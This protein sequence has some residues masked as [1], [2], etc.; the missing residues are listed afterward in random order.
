MH[1]SGTS[2]LTGILHYLGVE[3]GT[4]MMPAR[5]ENP[6]GFF[7]NQRV[8]E[9]NEA[10]LTENGSAWDD[11]GPE[12]E[13]GLVPDFERYVRKAIAVVKDQFSY[14]RTFAI[15]D[16]R[17]CRLF[18]VWRRA[19]EELGIDIAVV[20]PYRNPLEIASSLKRRNGFS[21]EKSIL[22]WADHV[23][24]AERHSRSLNR[25][26]ISFDRLLANDKRTI[27][28]LCDAL[29]LK[30]TTDRRKN[31]SAFLDRKL[32]HHYSPADNISDALPV[33]LLE[34]TQLL[35]KGRMND[36][37][38]LDRLR[39][40][41][42]SNRDFF[43]GA[44]VLESMP[45]YRQLTAELETR[46]ARIVE[47]QDEV[48]EKNQWAASLNQ[49]IEQL[50][51]LADRQ[52][53]ELEQRGGLLEQRDRELE[54][55][56]QW[57]ASLNQ[58]LE[59]LR[60]LA[61]RLGT[62]LEQSNGVLQQREQELEEKNQLAA[63]LD[64][65][66]EQLRQ[67]ADRLGAELE[68]RDG[69][70][71]Q[72]DR[73]LEEK[74]QRAA[75]LDQ[76]LEQLR[77]LAD[78]LGA[79]LEQ[80]N[81][82]LQQREQELEQARGEIERLNQL[83]QGHAAQVDS[84]NEQLA[85]ARQEAAELVVR[86]QELATE[87]DGIQR[88]LR[89]QLEAAL[90]KVAQREQWLEEKRV[91]REALERTY[92]EAVQGVRGLLDETRSEIAERD[93]RIEELIREHEKWRLSK[94]DALRSVNEQ[95]VVASAAVEEKTRLLELREREHA[96]EVGQYREE[97]ATL[98]D[99]IARL[100]SGN[101]ELEQRLDEQSLERKAMLSAYETALE[102]QAGKSRAEREE[103]VQRL[104]QLQQEIE[105][106]EAMLTALDLALDEVNGRSVH[107]RELIA[108]LEQAID[109]QEEGRRTES[110]EARM[111]AER[112]EQ[113][114]DEIGAMK[115]EL[116]Q[117]QQ[118]L[119]AVEARERKLVG[120]SEKIGM[121]C[122]NV[123]AFYHLRDKHGTALL[124]RSFR[125]LLDY[126]HPFGI[127][128]RVRHSL[129]ASR[130]VREKFDLIPREFLE[131]FDAGRYLDANPDVADAVAEG[132]FENALEHFIFY[133]YDEVRGGVRRLY[134]GVPGFNE[135]EY[136]NRYEDV[137]IAVAEGA[138][139]SGYD[140][141]LRYGAEE[142]L[143]GARLDRDVDVDSD[144]LRLFHPDQVVF[145]PG[146]LLQ[147]PRFDEPVV[148]I[149]IPAYNQA[150]FTFAC[151]ESVIA[152]SGAVPYEIIVLDDASPEETA[153]NL[154]RYI[155]NVR[156]VSNDENMGFLRN[157]NRGAALAKGRYILFLNNDTN[158]QP[159]W[160][161]PLV[162]LI[163][164]DGSIGMVGSRLVYPDGRQ[165]EAGGIIWKDASGWN[166]GRLDDPGKPEYN[167][168][169]EVDYLSGA[170]IMIRRSLWQ[171]IGG[172][173]ERYVPAYFEDS[174]L[175][176]EVR[177]HGYRVL[178][179]PKSV[180]VHFEGVS[181]GTD[182][183]QGIKSYQ[184]RNREL[185]IEKW[186]RE[187]EQRQ[188][189]N[190]EEVFLARDRSR[191]RPAILFVDHYVPHF[192]Q[193][194]GSRTV[195]AYLQLFVDQGFNVKF[196]GDNFF[197][198]QP[199]T[200]RLQQMGIE[201]LY[202]NWYA[203]NW[204]EWLRENG[205]YFDYVFL[206]R[207]HISVKYMDA[208][209]EHTHARILYYGHDLHFLR[210]MREYELH[211]D[212]TRLQSAERWKEIELGLMRKADVALYPSEVE[213]GEITSI[214]PSIRVRTIPAYLFERFDR[215]A[216]EVT[217]TSDIMFV[218]GFGHTPNID[219]VLWFASEVWPDVRSRL[220]D[221]RFH[222]IGS[223]PTEEILALRSDDINVTGF[224]SDDELDDYYRRT[225][226]SV[227]PLRYGA[228]IKGKVVEALYQGIPV[229]TT[230]TGAEGFQDAG[231]CLVVAETARG[232]ADAIVSLYQDEQRLAELS[233]AGVS[234]CERFFSFPAAKQ[235]LQSIVTWR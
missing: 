18:P 165:Q 115:R 37:E 166:F 183:E 117:K 64:Q 168:V 35:A 190:G 121:K 235:A 209:R 36:A 8:Y 57:A 40:E 171:R 136:L 73:E 198:H 218:G 173:D 88:L 130:K 147:V 219:A 152:N 48:E 150:A 23:L 160:L 159:D 211:H 86:Q 10:I 131:R 79:E 175:A 178:Y 81:G 76:E 172:F 206:N 217:D 16:P 25:F 69:L 59:Q 114:L 148:S 227:V 12:F 163:E 95:L 101:R 74:N 50:R 87:Q 102:R 11:I 68:Q 2:A 42:T 200:D 119:E 67:L 126:R 134:P 4:D 98:K 122:S 70:L 137:R 7:E 6:K 54:E 51:Q 189:P 123:E 30:L 220:P 103:L 151:I 133:G 62:E 9:L 20:V 143:R 45:R 49:E 93:R 112:M 234:Y 13:I 29:S 229:V 225:R 55:K 221:I 111:L 157:C 174:D 1:R 129:T 120:N 77:Q 89:S 193:D 113:A 164:S 232:L 65:E 202:G 233:R 205:R 207:P 140:H 169:K 24:D 97:I 138:F 104:E 195:L 3:M 127:V 105:A 162:H 153:R 5:D 31:I 27:Q 90:E 58:E 149:V 106:R 92:R 181:H 156:F 17:L 208:V 128:R 224:V 204:K 186:Q 176:F 231:E 21:L 216:G 197:P 196:I 125:E 99:R 83:I 158:V 116:A 146:N 39:L 66:L 212:E 124:N 179:Q 53:T 52:R 184:K 109:L 71:E 28:S 61:D 94:E 34:L 75:S 187:L 199:Y 19:L 110:S 182:L 78:R 100:E 222:V 139:A 14:S 38:K 32:R 155:D 180:V 223:K 228:G 230:P 43:L 41:F 85:G 170:A 144:G 44:E 63:S 108:Q 33:Y 72:R 91:E 177:R 15:K 56:N 213:V 22:L 107:E 145:D 203:N 215:P 142:I 201:V 80:N 135:E 188:F 46:L 210:E 132:Q 226:I 214:D 192:D 191:D 154:H 141:F 161:L 84:L 96:E 60:Q 47:L 185:F 118:A 82:V 194:A 167:Y 26:F